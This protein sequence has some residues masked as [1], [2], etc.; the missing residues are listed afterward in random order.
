MLEGKDVYPFRREILSPRQTGMKVKKNEHGVPFPSW[1]GLC[2]PLLAFFLGRAVLMGEL[3]PFGPAFLAAL[4]A[5]TRGF[6]WTVVLATAGGLATVLHGQQ[7]WVAWGT[8]ALLLILLRLY[9]V[10]AKKR[11]LVVPLLVIVTE[12][13]VKGGFLALSFPGLYGA[14]VVGSEALLAGALSLVFLTAFSTL[15]QKKLDC[16]ISGEEA[17]CFIIV[18]VGLLAGFDGIGFS[19][20]SLQGLLGRLIILLAAYAGGSGTGAAV[21]VMVGVVPCVAHLVAPATIGIYAFS[22]FLGGTLRHFHKLGVV[23][24]FLL[25]NL[26]LSVYWFDQET[27]TFALTESALAAFLL[28]CFPYGTITKL[29]AFWPLSPEMLGLQ[30]R[31]VQQIQEQVAGR[32]WE[33]VRVFEEFAL[34]FQDACSCQ[35][36]PADNKLGN[37]FEKI[38]SN[39]CEQCAIFH[40]CWEKELS[41]TYKSMLDMLAVAEA[42]GQIKFQDIPLEIRRHCLQPHDLATAVGYLYETYRV[43]EHWRQKIVESRELL[44]AQLQGIAA[45]M[46]ELAGQV[47][48]N[49]QFGMQLEGEISKELCSLGIKE[50][51]VRVVKTGEKDPEITLSREVP[52]TDASQCTSLLKPV[53]SQLVGQPLV[54]NKI[55]CPW[56]TGHEECRIKFMVAGAYTVLTGFAQANKSGE[57]VSGDSYTFLDLPSHKCALVLSDGMGTGPEAARESKAAIN[58]LSQLMGIGFTKDL[59]LKVINTILLAQSTKETFATLDLVLVDLKMGEVEFVKVGAAPTFIKRGEKLEIVS[60]SSLPM[61]I[62]S[63]VQADCLVKKLEVGDMLVMVTDGVLDVCQ[64]IEGREFWLVQALKEITGSNVQEV[65]ELLLHQAVTLSGGNVRDDMSI[66][67]GCLEEIPG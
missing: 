13:L 29:R 49:T 2:Y 42:K 66:L 60:S 61:G 17:A 19:H 8:L 48:D 67:V 18:L 58:L 1:E 4:L 43:N 65:A 31:K 23:S 41:R 56:K 32:L 22:G 36:E 24:G 26:M 5:T 57:I 25:G 27:L 21:G 7:L 53:L 39:V 15:R 35:P 52:C 12:T 10:N 14:L 11:W 45:V 47:Y 50:D 30:T 64:T 16:G 44:A 37:L 51:M 55:R 46:G 54:L 63:N 38:T 28:F 20:F 62:I 59:V 33:L 34:T 40:L 9:P 3:Y 6:T